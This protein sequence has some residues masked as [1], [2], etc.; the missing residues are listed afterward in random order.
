MMFMFLYVQWLLYKT[1]FMIVI[2]G[3]HG[4]STHAYIL[5]KI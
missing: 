1:L 3:T 2:V 4:K 5:T